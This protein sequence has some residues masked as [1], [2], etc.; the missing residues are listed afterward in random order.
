MFASVYSGRNR[1]S[2]IRLG[3]YHPPVLIADY[4]LRWT[5]RPW[6]WTIPEASLLSG[7]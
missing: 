1:D 5:S 6:S 3:P 4:L 7:P 2:S